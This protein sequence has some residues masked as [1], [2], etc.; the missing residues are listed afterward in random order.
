MGEA[1]VDGASTP[2]SVN[3]YRRVEGDPERYFS[4]EE[5]QKSKRYQRPLTRLGLLGSVGN[6][7]VIVGFIW[8][9]WAPGLVDRLNLEE[10]PI[11]LLA[12]ILAVEIATTI[13]TLP[14]SYYRTF[15]HEKNWGFS[16]ETVGGWVADQIKSLLI[17][18]IISGVLLT[19]LWWIIRSTDLW[20]LYGAIVLIVFSV[21]LAFLA[22]IVIMPLF[23]K[24]TPAEDETLRN[25]LREISRS[26]GIDLADVLVMDASKRTRHD[27]AFFTGLGKTKRVVIYDNMLSWDPELVDVVVAHEAGHW[28]HRHLLHG[29]V[30]GTVF[31]LAVFLGLK[32]FMEWKAA[33]DGAGVKSPGDPSALPLF[34]LGFGLASLLT[35]I[36]QTW[37]SRSH[38]RQADLFALNLVKNPEAFRRVWRQFS[39]KDLPDL[40]PSPW[41]RL[42]LSHPPIAERLAMGEV[43]ERQRWL[44]APGSDS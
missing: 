6:L 25:R 32:Y 39:E 38:E 22:P 21:I 12:I 2:V 23:N 41:K 10:W 20:W 8:G 1:V 4:P 42:T 16:T 19:A 31:A 24:F 40:D 29:I 3:V 15:V 18:L 37:L 14:I 9:N 27:N 43:W 7:I 44:L 28:K 13:P 34:M 26:G 17:G 30:T 36:P 11:Q 5:V 35:R 33:L